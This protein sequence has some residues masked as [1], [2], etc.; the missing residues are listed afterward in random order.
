MATV[1]MLSTFAQ[2]ERDTITQRMMA[3]K[4]QS[5]KN[6]NYINHAPFGYIR[7]NK[8]LIKDERLE[9]V[10]NIYLKD[11]LMVIVLLELQNY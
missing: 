1:G 8:R 4:I 5:V 10:L 2:L 11:Y 9:N 7:E 3:G 6:G